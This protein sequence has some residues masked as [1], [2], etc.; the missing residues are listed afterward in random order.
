MRFAD[1][2]RATSSRSLP[3][4][5]AQTHTIAEALRIVLTD[6]AP[7]IAEKGGLTLVG[8]TVMNLDDD[9]AVQLELPFDL[10]RSLALD[11]ALDDVRDR[12]GS[13]SV[14]RAVLLGHDPDAMVP[15]LPD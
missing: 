13:T 10:H 8:I 3:K 6:A 7:L 5:T 12:F 11:A 2:T 1:F 4:A 9:R 14:N 15:M